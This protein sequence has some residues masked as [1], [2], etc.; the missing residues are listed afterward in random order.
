MSR[1]LAGGPTWA[2]HLVA[3]GFLPEPGRGLI[4]AVEHA[5]LRGRGGAGFP[6]ATKLAAVAEGRRPVV[7][8]NGTEGEPMSAKD[9]LLLARAPHL[10]LD[11][12]VLAA[13]AVDAREVLV[14]APEPARVA[15]ALRERRDRGLEFRVSERA[16]GYV[17]GE[18]SAVI[19]HLEGRPARPRTKPPR[20]AE[21]G[22][23][24]RPTL[25]QNV[26]TLAH[27][28]LIAR[29]DW[30]DTRLVTVSGAVHAP[31]VREVGAGTQLTDLVAPSEPLRAVLVGGYFGAWV[32]AYGDLRL[33]DRMLAEH[34]AAVGAGVIVAL[35]RSACPVAETARLT[36]WLAAESAGQ[37][38]PCVHGL[39]ALAGVLQRIAAG[40]PE[41]E[42][43]Q[44]LARW[45]EMVRRRGACA[46][47]DG[48]ARM[49]ASARRLFAAELQDHAHNGPCAACRTPGTLATGASR[50][51]PRPVAVAA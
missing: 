23:R 2:E 3:H 27:I 24:R 10:V 1:L 49:L 35:G 42:D 20:P 48:A 15:A 43:F 32:P 17:A 18:E 37:C 31:G 44:R 21:R 50:P 25:V 7:V 6:T 5:G 9:A 38:G 41:R 29:G 51:A 22:Y 39:G 45:T 12:A 26:E 16:P 4:D 46:H 19:A 28:A 33:D 40:R 8:V 36:A 11:G 14:V 30:T 47:P 34:G 13:R